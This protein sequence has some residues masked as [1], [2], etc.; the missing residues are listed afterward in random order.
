M[1]DGFG[2]FVDRFHDRAS[3]SHQSFGLFP[4]NDGHDDILLN[5]HLHLALKAKRLH[6]PLQKLSHD[7]RLGLGIRR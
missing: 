1:E 2:D 5:L 4:A 7:G 6:Q 3:G